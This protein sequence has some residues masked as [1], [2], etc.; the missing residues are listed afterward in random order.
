MQ[1]DIGESIGNECLIFSRRA[2]RRGNLFTYFSRV[3]FEGSRGLGR[4]LERQDGVLRLIFKKNLRESCSRR[5]ARLGM[6]AQYRAL[7]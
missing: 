3:V 5:S 7:M 2:E 4:R 6:A 1:S